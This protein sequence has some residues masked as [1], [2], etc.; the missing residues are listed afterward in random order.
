MI[1]LSPKNFTL[2][3]NI[4]AK[5]LK[6]YEVWVFGSRV[7]GTARNYSDLDLVVLGDER[8]D[9]QRILAAKEAFAESD[10]TIRVDLINWEKLADSFRRIIL[11]KYEVIQEKENGKGGFNNMSM[12]SLAKIGVAI[13]EV[14][15]PLQALDLK[16][17]AVVACDQYTSEP[18]YWE[19]VATVVG[20]S[21]STLKMIFPEVYLEKGNATQRIAEIRENMEKYLNENILV[22]QQPGFIY[23]ERYTSK[24]QLRRGLVLALDLECYDYH[25]G[26][27]TLIRATEGTIIDR[28]P[29]RVKVREKALLESPHIMILVDDPACQ[30][31]EPLQK[32]KN[33]FTPAYETELMMK[34][35]RVN[36][37]LID[38]PEILAKIGAKLHE[39]I[40]PAVYTQKY[41]LPQNDAPL[42]FAVGDG[43]HSLAT[44]KAV[45]EK[46][47]S[48][49]KDTAEVM[50]H[51]A[52]YALVELVNLHD[53][54][55]IFEP[56]HRVVFNISLADFQKEM[57]DYFG[58]EVSFEPSTTTDLYQEVL[59]KR[60]T[61][62][63]HHFIGL[64]QEKFQGLIQIT[65]PQHNLEVGSLQAFL[66]QLLQNYQET[67]L[68]YVHG[69]KVVADLGSRPGNI[70]LYLPPMGKDSLFKTVIT[71][72]ALPRKTFSM[73]D[74]ED[75]R[76]YLE[77]RRI[78]Y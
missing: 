69:E 43:N 66:D 18:E 54:S 22:P 73:G 61:A 39:L 26:S 70:G 30:I 51:P 52:R 76:F 21:P 33:D 11:E 25:R 34:G 28:L 6:N 45:W 31:I 36:G 46:V 57:T 2:V 44:A 41:Q 62:K 64:V 47:K 10:L 58:G 29:P 74:A 15:L 12:D 53:S 60:A 32:M 65:K 55:L 37:Y 9:L 75:K 50:N 68:D 67:T 56:I 40:S 72:G 5:H 24:G 78:F 38:K 4:L 48:Q 59:T 71:E 16:K 19:E 3:K 8:L 17:W 20:E 7:K 42:L 27:K 14:L 35:G 63:E 13:P 49:A 1:D 77:C 23:V